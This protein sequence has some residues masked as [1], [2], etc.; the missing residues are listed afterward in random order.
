MEIDDVDL[1][2]ALHE[3]FAHAAK[4]RVVEIGIVRDYGHEPFGFSV[5]LILSEA[6]KLHVIV[7]KPFALPRT[8]QFRDAFAVFS[9]LL[10]DPATAVLRVARIG[11]V[12]SNHEHATLF[13]TQSALGFFAKR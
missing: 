7:L 8:T 9:D 2:E 5:H 6:Y 13:D 10:G 12:P 4:R 1:V 3:R 11:W